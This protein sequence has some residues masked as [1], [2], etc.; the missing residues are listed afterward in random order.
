MINKQ[1][2][3]RLLIGAVTVFFVVGYIL[4]PLYQLLLTGL[5][6]TNVIAEMGKR[7]VLQAGLNSLLLSVISVIGSAVVGIYFAYTFHYKKLWLKTL[8]S[9]LVLLPIA[10]PPMVGVMSFLFLLGDN[11]LIMKV[12][13]LKSFNFSGWTAITL[14]HIYSFYPLF[15]L[16]GGIALRNIDD[17]VIEASY[18]LGAKKFKTFRSIILPLLK[19]ALIGTIHLWQ[20][21]PFS[22][23][24][25]L[26]RQD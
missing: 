26:L 22:N 3:P 9:T 25:D 18:A 8:F 7:H 20:L 11:G 4:Y 24:R 19:P 1:Q 12:L 16:F 5:A 13:G 14:V 2:I 6:Q 23:Y 21:H 17:S 10:I 15:Y